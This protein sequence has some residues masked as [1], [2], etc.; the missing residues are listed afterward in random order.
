MVVLY[1][2]TRNAGAE[3]N[4]GILLPIL[5]SHQEKT[6]PDSSSGENPNA[7]PDV[8]I[9]TSPDSVPEDSAAQDDQETVNTEQAE[10]TD[11]ALSDNP[12][13]PASVQQDSGI[14]ADNTNN[15]DY[16]QDGHVEE[17]QTYNDG[18]GEQNNENGNT[19]NEG[20]TTEENG[21]DQLGDYYQEGNGYYD[22]DGRY[23]DDVERQSEDGV[24][25]N[26][27]GW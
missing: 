10:Q 4:L 26:E 5:E 14:N 21:G 11:P 20:E 9:N 16:A 27:Q 19:Y 6:G 2:R 1:F 12:V 18:A 17:N 24:N 7:E 3:P 13:D 23:Y 15:V 8:D 22:D 25:E